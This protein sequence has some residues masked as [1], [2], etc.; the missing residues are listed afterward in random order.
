MQDSYFENAIRIILKYKP[1][2]PK[3]YKYVQIGNNKPF[4]FCQKVY[5]KE[6]QKKHK[7]IDQYSIEQMKN[8]QGNKNKM[9]DTKS[10][11]NVTPKCVKC[12][13]VVVNQTEIKSKNVDMLS[14][15][16][17]ER[18]YLDNMSQLEIELRKESSMFMQRKNFSKKDFDNK[19]FLEI[20][21][22]KLK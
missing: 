4:T 9:N 19:K 11:P 8:D 3:A 5:Q 15:H 16:F 21:N 17:V 10:D 22:K 12:S 2:I 13:N 14:K 6:I 18:T 20:L 1:E 7:L